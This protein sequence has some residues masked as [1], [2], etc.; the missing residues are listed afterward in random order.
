MLPIAR[1]HA[2]YVFAVLQSGLTTVIA[3][4]IASVPMAKSGQFLT[5]W[6][7]AWLASWVL[8]API[9]IVAAPFVRRAALALTKDETHPATAGQHRGD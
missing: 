4:G 6:L 3:S 1:H 2:H 9:V 7:S 5:H 8:M